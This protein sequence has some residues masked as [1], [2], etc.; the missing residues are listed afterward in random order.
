MTDSR[1]K[2]SL[3]VMAGISTGVF[4]G[5]PFLVPQLLP[6]YSP[7]E[8][9]FGR[10]AFFGL[11][12]VLFLKKVIHLIRSLTNRDRIFIFLLSAS[13]FWFYSM[14][15]FWGVQQ[16]DGVIASLIIG[17]LPLTIPLCSPGRKSGGFQFYLGLSALLLGLVNLFAY[18]LLTGMKAVK[19][20][21]WSGIIALIAS[22]S[23]W[24]WFAISNSR[25][26]RTRSQINRKDFASVI[27]VVSLLSILPVF[28]LRVDLSELSGR[29]NFNSYLIYSAALG[30]GSS[31]IANWLWN[32]CS[33]HCPSEISGPLIVSETIFGLLYSFAFERRWPFAY[34]T[35]SIVLFLLGV[36]LAVTA[37]LKEHRN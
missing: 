31:W 25:F 27:G 3:G 4:W 9:A 23:L 37:Q 5:I 21:A 34:E 32:I 11:I 10:F 30:I 2:L 20:P 8:I 36:T 15:L 1:K 33:F 24:T 6:N 19:V 13:G 29:G 17:L 22:L 14:L 7:L 28:L 26:L 16:T 35:V 12:S 18:P